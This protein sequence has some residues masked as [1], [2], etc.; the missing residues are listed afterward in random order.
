MLKFSSPLKRMAKN[1]EFCQ[2]VLCFQ[3]RIMKFEFRFKSS[4]SALRYVPTVKLSSMSRALVV[5]V[6]SVVTVIKIA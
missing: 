4:W 2:H 1:G 5:K 6:N 3:K